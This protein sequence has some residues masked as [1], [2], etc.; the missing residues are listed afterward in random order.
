MCTNM[1]GR[2]SSSGRGAKG[3]GSAFSFTFQPSKQNEVSKKINSASEFNVSKSTITLK[4]ESGKTM[5]MIRGIERLSEVNT[6]TEF[7]I[8]GQLRR[9]GITHLSDVGGRQNIFRL[10]NQI[11]IIN[12]TKSAVFL[13]NLTIS[14]RKNFTND[15]EKQKIKNQLLSNAEKAGIIIINKK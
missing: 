7:E 5:G 2:G 12:N 13:D 15:I 10:D 9:A 14:Q 4:N 3:G 6:R 11:Y 8:A 1:G